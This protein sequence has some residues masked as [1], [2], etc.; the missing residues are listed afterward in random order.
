MVAFAAAALTML[1]ISSLKNAIRPAAVAVA[2][3][4]LVVALVTP[5]RERATNVARW[6][7]SGDYNTVFTDRFTPF[8]AAWSMFV[9]HPLTGVGPGAFPWQYYDY[10]IRA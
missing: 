4:V 3:G 1:A 6:V 8:V 2:A 9:D 10:K 7:R 5:L